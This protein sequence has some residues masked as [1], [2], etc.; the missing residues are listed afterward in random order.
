[1]SAQILVSRNDE[2]NPRIE[3]LINE[4]LQ[5][6]YEL[7]LAML[8]DNTVA[9]DRLDSQIRALETQILDYDYQ[10]Y[11]EKKKLGIF[12][13]D[14]YLLN[15]ENDTSVPEAVAIKLKEIIG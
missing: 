4:F 11:F 13:V 6:E 8:Q 14:H 1:M 10:Y 12:L 2:I 7:K 3:C 9:I 5:M 15:K